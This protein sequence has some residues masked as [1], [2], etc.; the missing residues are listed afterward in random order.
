VFAD[1]WQINGCPVNGPAVAAA[2]KRV[3]VA[4]FTG[5]NNK[6]QVKLAFSNDAG[7]TF[8][9]P[10]VIDDGNPAGRVDV[11]LLADGSAMVS[12]LEKLE[13]GGAVRLR[14]VKPDGTRDNSITIAPSGTARSS[15]FPQMIRSGNSLVFAWVANRVLTAELSFK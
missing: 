13:S 4:W 9:T 12:W 7:E 8:G 11:L 3:A 5:A 10:V 6:S 14:Q 1:G 2:D 15:G